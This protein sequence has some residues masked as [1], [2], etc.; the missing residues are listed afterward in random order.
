MVANVAIVQHILTARDTRTACTEKTAQ[1]EEVAECIR[2]DRE[3]GRVTALLV[4]AMF[5][6]TSGTRHRSHEDWLITTVVVLTESHVNGE[7][8]R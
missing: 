4:L 6:P 2:V 7:L 8:K 1:C 5:T 3:I